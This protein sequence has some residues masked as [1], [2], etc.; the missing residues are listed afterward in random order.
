MI[1]Y[2]SPQPGWR[3]VSVSDRQIRWPSFCACCGTASG[4]LAPVSSETCPW[5]VPYCPDCIRHKELY[6]QAAPALLR[7]E[8]LPNDPVDYWPHACALALAASVSLFCLLWLG[9][10]MPLEGALA[11]AGLFLAVLVGAGL[12]FPQAARL[13]RGEKERAIA[14]ARQWE[15]HFCPFVRPDCAFLGPA[16]NYSRGQE[17]SHIF[18]FGSSV[19]AQKFIEANEGSVEP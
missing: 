6:S 1:A 7:A 3:K 5:D 19:Y 17:G 2:I 14:E 18:L 8:R 4:E 9:W 16:V 15:K 12:Y 13:A 10:E 11:G